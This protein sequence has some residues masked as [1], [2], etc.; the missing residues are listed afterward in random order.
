MGRRSTERFETVEDVGFQSPLL[1]QII[2]SLPR[3][4]EPVQGL[5]KEI[6]LK[7]AADGE[8]EAIWTDFDKY[9]EIA[10]AEMVGLFSLSSPLLS[11]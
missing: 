5:T 9:P 7:K 4:K 6:H 1:N 2:F 11:G 10:E 8:I 3:I